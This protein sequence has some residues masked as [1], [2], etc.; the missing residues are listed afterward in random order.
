M[1]RRWGWLSLQKDGLSGRVCKFRIAYLCGSVYFLQTLNFYVNGL[2]KDWLFFLLGWVCCR[3]FSC[4]MG[5]IFVQSCAWGGIPFGPIWHID[6]TFIRQLFFRSQ[7]LAKARSR[8]NPD[9]AGVTRDGVMKMRAFLAL[10][11]LSS[12]APRS[13]KTQKRWLFCRNGGHWFLVWGWC[14]SFFFALFCSFS[15][16]TRERATHSLRT[17][18]KNSSHVL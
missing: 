5:V 14:L 6:V 18:N 12:N 2:I 1:V 3:R 16:I 8:I 10:E 11:S 7:N 9:E 4:R 17:K 13:S 15:L